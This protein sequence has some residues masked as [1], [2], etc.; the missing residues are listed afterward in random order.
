MTKAILFDLFGT[1]VDYSPRLE[2]KDFSATYALLKKHFPNGD[3]YEGF[4]E[5]TQNVFSQLDSA[6][7]SSFNEFSMADVFEAYLC[8]SHPDAWTCSQRDELTEQYTTEWLKHVSW[9]R[10][11]KNFISD[12]KRQYK[13]GLITN[14]HHH[15]MILKLLDTIG[16]QDSFDVVLTS[17]EHGQRKPHRSIFLAATEALGLSPQDCLF[18]GDSLEADVAGAVGVGMTP[19][20]VNQEALEHDASIVSVRSVFD[21]HATAFPA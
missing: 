17:V 16:I 2:G 21:L 15:P 3:S 18:V 10:E 9:S 20:W 11:L 6:S 5:T 7:S 13:V 19:I 1:L 12:L 4:L 14:T 8:A